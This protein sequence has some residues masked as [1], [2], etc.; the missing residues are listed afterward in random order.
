MDFSKTAGERE[1]EGGG[2]RASG[3]TQ[4]MLTGWQE[5]SDMAR[6]EGTLLLFDSSKDGST[7]RLHPSLD[8]DQRLLTESHRLRRN[9]RA[10]MRSA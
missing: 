10:N 8:P 5:V 7:W 4:A 1:R 6:G 3:L 2:G 9:E